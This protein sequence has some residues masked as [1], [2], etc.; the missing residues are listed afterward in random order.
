ME[1]ESK[2][3][4]NTVENKSGFIQDIKDGRWD[5]VLKQVNQ[6]DIETEKLYDLYEQV[7]NYLLSFNILLID[8][9]RLHWN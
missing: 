6:L 7:I 1:K 9:H 8:L 5:V 4:L 2:Q 3:T